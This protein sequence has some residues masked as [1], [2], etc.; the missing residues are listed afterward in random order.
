VVAIKVEFQ[1]IIFLWFAFSKT[2]FMHHHSSLKVGTIT[3]TLVGIFASIT[4]MDIEK[5]IVLGGIGAA[6]SFLVS[7]F[8]KKIIFYGKNI[9]GALPRRNSRR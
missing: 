4:W 9:M 3:G 7:L 2:V 1:Q 5:T 6:V 8:L